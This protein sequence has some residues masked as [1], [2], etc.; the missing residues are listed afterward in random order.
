METFCAP[1]FVKPV[2]TSVYF[3]CRSCL[4]EASGSTTAQ[5]L[6]K[7]FCTI[8]IFCKPSDT[9]TLW[10]MFKC[11][12]SE[13]F[14]HNQQSADEAEN[15][16]LAHLQTLL[17]THR[18]SLG[19]FGLPQPIVNVQ[20]HTERWNVLEERERESSWKMLSTQPWSKE[21]FRSHHGKSA[22]WENWNGQAFLHW[23]TWWMWKNIPLQ[24]TAF[25]CQRDCCEIIAVASSGIAAEL[26]EGER[27]AHSTFKIP[28]PIQDHST[29]RISKQSDLAKKI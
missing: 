9:A 22:I 14:R 21:S 10:T 12:M 18:K 19:D 29:C 28:I 25:I 5:Q 4:R 23:W 16:T 6:P 2:I 8:I 15:L 27:T 3:E 17:C 20:E 24:H 7:L 26:L 1:P 13:D 11:S